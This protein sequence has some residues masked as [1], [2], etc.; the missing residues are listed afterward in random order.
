MSEDGGFV[1]DILAS[2]DLSCADLVTEDQA[3]FHT[4]VGL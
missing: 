2:Y 4:P 1:N 3:C